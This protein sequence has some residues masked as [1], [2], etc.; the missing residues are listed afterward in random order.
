MRTDAEIKQWID[1]RGVLTQSELG[2]HIYGSHQAFINRNKSLIRWWGYV[3]ET[4][5]VKLIKEYQK[6]RIE[7]SQRGRFRNDKEKI[8]EIIRSNPKLGYDRMGKLL[9]GEYD[10]K[11]CTDTV[12]RYYRLLGIK[13]KWQRSQD[14]T[15]LIKTKEFEGL[16][17]KKIVDKL[18][19]NYGI[20][21]HSTTIYRF[22]R[23]IFKYSQPAYGGVF[24]F[25]KKRRK[26]IQKMILSDKRLANAGGKR[27]SRLLSNVYNIKVHPDTFNQYKKEALNQTIN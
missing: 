8:C 5:N 9:N 21:Y 20:Q 16:S 27:G 11:V 1:E 23:G 4:K 6:S 15:R 14:V 22:L 25:W 10:I 3:L 26:D 19:T 12:K 7:K 2:K 24:R 13:N 17:I 18:L